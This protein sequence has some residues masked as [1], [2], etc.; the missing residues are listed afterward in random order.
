MMGSNRDDSERPVH[1]VTISQGFYVGKYEVTQG[2]W[3][4]LMGNN[5]SSFKE[6]G[7]NC[8]VDRVS[9]H[10]AQAFIAKLNEAG[11]GVKYRLP[12]ESEWEYACRARTTG[13]YYAPFVD[14]IGWF[15]ENSGQK[16]Q[17][18]GGKQPNAF[19]LYDMLGNVFELCNDWYHENYDGAPNDGSAWLSGGGQK[20]RVIRGGSW[21]FTSVASRPANRSIHLPDD[22]LDGVGFRV[23]GVV[24][25]Q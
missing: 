25:I 18:V 24:G 6:C 11:D 16:P 2:Q 22:H 14:D 9:L 1:E 13:D 10:D 20:F 12:S 15:K 19:G 3:Q 17:A 21:Y 8:P 4:A 5:P 7:A 23:V